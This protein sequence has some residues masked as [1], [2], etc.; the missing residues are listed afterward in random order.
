MKKLLLLSAAAFSVAL[1]LSN[2]FKRP[3][4]AVMSKECYISCYNLSTP[5]AMR[6]EMSTAAFGQLHDNPLAFTLQNPIG[7]M[8]SFDA[9]G[10]KA[11]GYLIKSKKKSSKWLLVIQ[12]WWGLN[13]YIK[14]EAE[15]YYKDLGDVNVLA[16][17]MYDGKVATNRDSAAK[18]V[19]SADPKRLESIVKGGI[20][21]AGSKAKIYT[22]GWCF[23]GGWSLQ[24]S[25]L[26]GKQGA[27]CVMFYGRPENNQDKLKQLNCDVI[28]FFG[29]KDK[30]PS[31]EVVDQFIADM[32]AAGKNLEVNR[33]DAGHGFANPSNPGFDK[34]AT[35][36]AY[37]KAIAFLKAR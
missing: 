34:A 30:S 29:N 36:D 19:Q 3:A 1:L 12:E 16:L 37:G 8:I 22:V 6:A 5:E 14:R 17:D 24:A 28:G 31:P 7:E 23:G 10:G 35:A 4:P 32:K 11:Q 27:G 15:T 21:Y 25:I 20:Q 13:D 26:A 33:Y 2:T 9:E 18:Y